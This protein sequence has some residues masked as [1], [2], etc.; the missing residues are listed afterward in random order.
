[1]ALEKQG[2]GKVLLDEDQ[3]VAITFLDTIA[4]LISEPLGLFSPHLGLR[5]LVI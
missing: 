3:V 2:V 5:K 4:N 1:M